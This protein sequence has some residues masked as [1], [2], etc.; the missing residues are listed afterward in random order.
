ML[1]GFKVTN[2]K[3]F[4]DETVLPLVTASKIRNMPDHEVK[5]DNL[6][7]LKYA[8]VFGG[9]ASGKTNLFSALQSMKML[10]VEGNSKLLSCFK[11]NDRY[12]GR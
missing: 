11:D 1:L 4:K 9:N 5:F 10:L 3:S 12:L 6:S 7:V 2:Y 8:S